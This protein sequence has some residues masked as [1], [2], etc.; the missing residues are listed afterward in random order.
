[1]VSVNS[2]RESYGKLLRMYDS[3][4]QDKKSQVVFF[5]KQDKKRHNVQFQRKGITCIFSSKIY[6]TKSHIFKY[7]WFSLV[8]KFDEKYIHFQ[9]SYMSLMKINQYNFIFYHY[10][11]QISINKDSKK[12]N[13]ISNMLLANYTHLRVLT[14]LYIHRRN[15]FLMGCQK[16]VE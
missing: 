13:L 8:H 11:G 9:K 7:L 6:R 2:I 12:I 15:R 4:S 5:N 10:Q 1:M 3:K 14:S 16:D